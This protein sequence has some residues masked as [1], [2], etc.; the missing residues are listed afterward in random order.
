MKISLFLLTALLLLNSCNSSDGKTQKMITSYLSTKVRNPNSLSIRN[1][2]IYETNPNS[3]QS[4]ESKKN[5]ISDKSSFVNVV[6][7]A[8][9]SDGIEVF[10]NGTLYFNKTKDGFEK[11]FPE[12]LDVEFGNLSGSCNFLLANLVT[13][14]STQNYCDGGNIIAVNVDSLAGSKKYITRINNGTYEIN[15]MLPGEY[16]IKMIHYNVNLE[17]IYSSVGTNKNYFLLIEIQKIMSFYKIYA[18][19]K[20]GFIDKTLF[21]VTYNKLEAFIK[22]G[23][24][25]ETSEE[26]VSEMWGN[27]KKSVSRNFIDDLEVSDDYLFLT[28]FYKVIVTPSIPSSQNMAIKNFFF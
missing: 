27:F 5:Q 4:Y 13:N 1:Y 9:N 26:E 8:K 11:S 21:N 23:R 24:E 10:R 6:F 22:G 7:S 16:F 19:R 12:H 15:R 20:Y 25:R 2:K 17:N 28:K 18:W 3:V 14:W